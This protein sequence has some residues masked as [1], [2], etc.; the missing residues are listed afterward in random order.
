MDMQCGFYSPGYQVSQLDGSSNKTLFAASPHTTWTVDLTRL[1]HERDILE[2]GLANCVTYLHVLRKKQARNERLLNLEPAPARK[3]RKKIQ[4]NKRDLDKEIRNRQR[5]EEA[6]LSGLQTCKANIHIAEDYSYVPTETS[7]ITADCTSSTTTTQMLWDGSAPMEISW[8]GWMDGAFTSPFEKER[9]N[10]FLVHN[11]APDELTEPDDDV[12]TVP[13]QPRPL[14]LNRSAREFAVRPV[15]PNTA[16]LDIRRSSLSPEAANFKPSIYVV[17]ANGHE[18]LTSDS[19]DDRETR[20]YT[21][22]GVCR[23][24]QQLSLDDLQYGSQR[25]H[26]WCQTTPQQSPRKGSVGSSMR[27]SRTNSL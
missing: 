3:K 12:I 14:L 6:F 24:I 5:D 10:P 21:E 17:A 7:S 2:K 1:R 19:I 15:P 20:R 16:C 18:L 11:V 9:S 27:R 4:Q 22:A 25:N 23:A 8:S 13:V 26:T